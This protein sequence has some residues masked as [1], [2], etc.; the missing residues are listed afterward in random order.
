MSEY[1]ALLS[2]ANNL[3]SGPKGTLLD[4][5]NSVL[6]AGLRQLSIA[7]HQRDLVDF[8]NAS[9]LGY[10]SDGLIGTEY[11]KNIE[12]TAL[13]GTYKDEVGEIESNR[14]FVVLMAYDFQLLWKKKQHKLL[15]ET[16]F[17]INEGH[18]QFDVALPVM[19][20][21]AS[22]Y[23]GENTKGMVRKEIRQGQV[24][25]GEVKSLG[26]VVPPEK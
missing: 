2:E 10:D 22:K 6:T 3:P 9:M 24:D 15:W 11:G 16:R 20:A 4:E 26:E 7:N 12:H 18:N 25:I 13:G 23:F 1:N 5:A 8:K 19:A 17:S 14:Y 21:D